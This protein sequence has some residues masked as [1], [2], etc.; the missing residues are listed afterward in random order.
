M[1]FKELIKLGVD[2]SLE[3]GEANLQFLDIGL[4]TVPP[5]FFRKQVLEIISKNQFKNN[6]N[7]STQGLCCTD[8][9]RVISS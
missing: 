1:A 3:R 9:L 7:E 8:K 5:S 6:Y 2:M 4:Q